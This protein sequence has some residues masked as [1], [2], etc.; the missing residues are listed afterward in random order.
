MNHLIIFA[1]GGI[2]CAAVTVTFGSALLGY[3]VALAI[4]AGHGMLS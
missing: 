4:G 3:A 2:M 1:F